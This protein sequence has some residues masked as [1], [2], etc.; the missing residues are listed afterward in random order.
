M[1]LLR[2]F[3]LSS[4]QRKYLRCEERKSFVCLRYQ[5][6]PSKAKQHRRAIPSGWE[7]NRMLRS[8]HTGK[9][10][11]FVLEVDNEMVP[12]SLSKPLRPISVCQYYETPIWWNVYGFTLQRKLGSSR[13]LLPGRLEG[14]LSFSKKCLLGSRL[15]VQLEV[16]CFSASIEA[17]RCLEPKSR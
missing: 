12:K 5:C 14:S 17:Q 9:R 10:R 16:R 11:R 1:L 4:Q 2:C 8:T 15:L 13:L 7:L 6:R 3:D